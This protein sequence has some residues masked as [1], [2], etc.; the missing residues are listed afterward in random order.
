MFV[1]LCV[2]MCVSVC[3]HVCVSVC[4]HVCVSVCDYVCVSVCV[5]SPLRTSA[6]SYTHLRAY[7]TPEHLVCRL[8]LEKNK[9]L[10]FY[11]DTT[12]K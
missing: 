6:G 10:L 2:I 11:I 9:F 4:D 7:E 5:C 8:L 1:F 3:D 12:N